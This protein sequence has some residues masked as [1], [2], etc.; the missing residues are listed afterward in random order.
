MSSTC[1]ILCV[2]LVVIVW[3]FVCALFRVGTF[4]IVLGVDM[5]AV[6]VN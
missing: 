3:Y 5:L 2:L 4:G 1:L 6:V